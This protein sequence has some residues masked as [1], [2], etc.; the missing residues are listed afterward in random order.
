MINARLNDRKRAPTWVTVGAPLL[1]VPILVALL[2]VVAPRTEADVD[3][4]LAALIPGD[5]V[6]VEVMTT[7][8]G[9]PT[10]DAAGAGA[11]EEVSLEICLVP[12]D[13]ATDETDIHEG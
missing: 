2:S 3:D 11:I 4:E 10:P 12:C 6:T 1:G 8:R 13:S 5:P 7:L 9:E